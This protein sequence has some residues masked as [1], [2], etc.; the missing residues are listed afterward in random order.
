MN[1]IAQAMGTHAKAVPLSLVDIT[2][3]Q[4]GQTR[5]PQMVNKAAY[6]SVQSGPL[7]CV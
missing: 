7:G 6:I 2:A 1:E 5:L 4:V 3:P